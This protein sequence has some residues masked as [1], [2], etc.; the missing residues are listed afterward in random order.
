[1]AERQKNAVHQVSVKLPVEKVILITMILLAAIILGVF[2]FS[3][4]FKPPQNILRNT[5]AS[6]PRQCKNP[7]TVLICTR[8]TQ[9]FE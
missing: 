3:K 8:N 1:M 4:I 5:E 2:F 6:S 7:F 9:S